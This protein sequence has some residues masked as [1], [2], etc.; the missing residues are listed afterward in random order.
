MS[1]QIH[2]GLA[3][4]P[5]AVVITQS[6]RQALAQRVLDGFDLADQLMDHIKDPRTRGGGLRLT[7]MATAEM[8]NTN[9]AALRRLLETGAASYLFTDPI[10]KLDLAE[11]SAHEQLQIYNYD[12]LKAVAMSDPAPQAAP[13]RPSWT[14]LQGAIN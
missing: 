14:E 4:E 6:E 1:N 12:H 10:A 13:A 2:V 3:Q 9:C 8:L 7:A 5:P 11:A